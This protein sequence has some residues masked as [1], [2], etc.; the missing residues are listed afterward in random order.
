M[1]CSQTVALNMWLMM[2]GRGTAE[3]KVKGSNGIS[4]N[5]YKYIQSSASV[6]G[7]LPKILMCLFLVYTNMHMYI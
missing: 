6:K 1:G 4:N 2:V 5:R 7:W 3:Y